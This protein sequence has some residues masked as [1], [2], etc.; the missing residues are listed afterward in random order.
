MAAQVRATIPQ[1]PVDFP[2]WQVGMLRRIMTAKDSLAQVSPDANAQLQAATSIKT[3][4]MNN[5]TSRANNASTVAQ[6]ER[7]SQR[8]DARARETNNVQREAQQTQLINDPN[9]GVIL[10]NKGTKTAIPAT[11]ADGSRVPSENAVAA[12]KLNQQLQAGITMARDLIPKATASGMGE[13]R[14]KGAAFF[15]SST[16]GSEA[17]SQLQTL[18]GWMTANVPRMQGPQ[19]DKD[20]MLYRQMAADVGNSSLPAERRLAALDTLEKLQQK[21]ADISA[22]VAPN[23]KPSA[24]RSNNPALPAGWTVEKH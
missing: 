22:A 21:Y 14:D 12:S 3:T 6:A 2:K 13:L 7:A 24:A 9:L 11:F 10:V 1:N 18:A 23:A 16:A 17:A 19:S 4:G 20:V 5:D 8:A 15:G